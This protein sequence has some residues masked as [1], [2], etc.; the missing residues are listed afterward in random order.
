MASLRTQ[1]LG[2]SI[3]WTLQYTIRSRLLTLS[4]SS[5]ERTPH[6]HRS[7]SHA[8]SSSS[9]PSH[10]DFSTHTPW[11]QQS[12]PSSG[13]PSRAKPPPPTSRTTGKSES[14]A[15]TGASREPPPPTS[16]TVESDPPR[17]PLRDVTQTGLSDMPNSPSGEQVDWTTSFQGLSS[18]AFSKETA[19][20]L[21]Q[22]LNSDDI[23]I[24]PDGIV[25]LPE[26]KYRRI[27][28]RA[29]GPGGWGLAPRGETI[30][31]AKC[32]TRE[33]ALLANGR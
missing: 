27:L 19:D 1:R 2:A 13:T 18:E 14:A 10:R 3:S 6:R 24:K 22:P 4:L 5:A 28:N 31:T 33:Y 21:L 25:F 30:V 20:I 29:F 17:E 7:R 16:R 8:H 23:E 11:L 9:N 15:S 26:I 32:V 12:A